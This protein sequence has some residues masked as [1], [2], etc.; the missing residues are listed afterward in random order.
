M[1]LAALA[2]CSAQP[3]AEPEA[4]S[5]FARIPSA[6]A[7]AR[8][9]D[10]PGS[11]TVSAVAADTLPP[12]AAEASVPGEDPAA[13]A[14]DSDIGVAIGLLRGDDPEAGVRLL[15][16][17]LD[18]GP[19][20]VE[21]A[22]VLADHLGRSERL[23]EALAV[24]EAAQA[25]V[26]PRVALALA[27]GRVLL[28][29]GLCDAAISELEG[30]AE[31]QP[32]PRIHSMLA[33]AEQQRGRPS[34]ALQHLAALHA[35]FVDHPWVRMHAVELSRF[36]ETLRRADGA[37]RQTGRQLLATLRS[38][39]S[40]VLRVRAL[41]TLGAAHA[42][43]LE[44]ALRIGIAD[45]DHVVRLCA[46]RLGFGAVVDRV[47][48]VS[49]GLCDRSALVRGWAARLAS[50]LPPQTAIPLL[51]SFLDAERDG[52]VVGQMNRSLSELLDGPALSAG[53]REVDHAALERLR[54]EWHG[55]WRKSGWAQ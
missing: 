11:A 25:Q 31:M 24:L 12:V 54:A 20:T 40:T 15:R 30:V 13:P 48:W 3:I 27:R 14:P 44:P 26:G 36:E 32:H 19:H 50:L 28:D 23:P 7:A 6:R 35:Q 43:E 2:A 55:R 4:R 51:L 21:A 52:Y 29:L 1:A 34:D 47:G 37:E 10:E 9:R 53:D 49:D 8:E 17:Q 42:P 22:L 33:T 46:L 39:E 18:G 16:E 45:P 41:Q 5:P 38:A